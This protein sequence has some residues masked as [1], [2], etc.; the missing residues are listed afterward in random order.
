MEGIMVGHVV[1]RIVERL[2]NIASNSF[3]LRLNF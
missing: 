3:E 2:V 1:N